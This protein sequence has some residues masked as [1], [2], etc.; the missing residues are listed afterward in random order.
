MRH[1]LW[2]I[3]ESY[4]PTIQAADPAELQAR[5][6]GDGS[7]SDPPYT[8]QHGIAIVPI[9]GP[10]TKFGA[11]GGVATARIAGA[12]LELQYL[13]T[14]G[15]AFL[16]FDTPGGSVAGTE[17]LAHAVAEL[18]RVKPVH[19]HV[20]DL[21]A[22]A[23]MWVASQ[24]G[25]LTAEPASEV[26]SI[27]TFTLIADSSELFK[28]KGITIHTI[29]SGG[30]KGGGADG[31]PITNEHLAEIQQR[32]NAF[33]A[34]FTKGVSEGRKIPRALVREYAD[35]RLHMA[36][37]AKRMRL[38]DAVERRMEAHL[39]LTAATRQRI[40]RDNRKSL[41]AEQTATLDDFLAD[42]GIY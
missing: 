3:H 40:A 23:G 38:I 20:E 15:G 6:L 26:G 10:M 22:S 5:D 16:I 4:L 1:D 34:L 7:F 30:V 14:V 17:S 2:A 32:V 21:C 41:R 37:A 12:L 8:I 28:Q 19:G 11:F 36:P 31:T 9:R 29:A 42:R 27:G 39:G 33:Q 35:G 24:C 25:R 18:N 13:N